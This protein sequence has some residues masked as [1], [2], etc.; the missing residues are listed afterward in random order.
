VARQAGLTL[1]LP[2]L[3]K[4]F[5][6][7]GPHT[8]GLVLSGGEPTYVPHFPETVALAKA[9]GFMEI[10]VISNGT[11]LHLM[12]VQNALLEHVTSVRISM[13]DWQE[14][15]SD[16]FLEILK[17][18]EFL[19]DRA[20]KEGST[21]EIGAAMLTRKEWNH[22]LTPAGLRVLKSGVDW[23]YFHPYCI[24]W[25]SEHPVQA[26]QNGVLEAIEDLIRSAPAGS[27]IQ[28]PYERYSQVP[29][30]FKR[31][32]GAHFLI[33]VGADGINYAG[34][35]CKYHEDYALLDLNK[36]LEDDFLWH[37]QR[38]KRL[39]EISSDN[40][41]VI[42]TR[43]RPPMFSD[44]IERLLRTRT[45]EKAPWPSIEEDF[46]LYPDII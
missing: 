21:L 31:L 41:R 17:K 35:E 9:K 24:N 33:Q 8:P 44:Y 3:E 18:I 14:G 45:A 4:L 22:R 28:T 37:P 27:N 25:E 40:Y 10:A 2:F 39:Q 16:A 30:F 36:Y 34:P 19:R 43:H 13:Y 42:G 46:F 7:L 1:P 5:S 15:D 38:I 32:H 20:E 6:I 29:L 12:A 26:D 23:L 11:R